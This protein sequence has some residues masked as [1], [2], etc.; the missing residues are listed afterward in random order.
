ML[1]RIG[2]V[3]C[4]VLLAGMGIGIC[5]CG[6]GPVAIVNGQKISAR[7]FYSFAVKGRNGENA[8]T[9][10]ILERMVL[11]AA[12]K[13]GV[14]VSDKEIADKIEETRKSLAEE[15]GA[16]SLEEV[17]QSESLSM[18]DL[19]WETRISLLVEKMCT[20]DVKVTEEQLKSY[21]DQNRAKM[22]DKPDRAD[23]HVMVLASEKEAAQARQQLAQGQPFEKLAAEKSLQF[24]SQ[25]GAVGQVNR[26]SNL[27]PATV[28]DAAYKLSVGDITQVLKDGD[29]YY[30][31]RLDSKLAAEQADYEKVKDRVR[32]DYLRSNGTPVQLFLMN[33]KE[34]AKVHILWD[35]FADLEKQFAPTP[36]PTLPTPPA[37]VGKGEQPKP[38]AAPAENP[39]PEKGKAGS[40]PR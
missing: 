29:K 32:R 35:Q 16:P 40:A 10:L 39:S 1:K 7:D 27:I 38:G 36:A 31:A 23:L 3:A 2:R 17:L 5:S 11:Q 20:K 4:W 14:T 19:R 33:L 12:Q 13:E 37:P 15:P 26:D 8:L 25:Q 22:Y 24:Q 6:K 34:D 9:G 30:L 18:D 21:F 28:F